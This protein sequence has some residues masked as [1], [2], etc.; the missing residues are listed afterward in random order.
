MPVPPEGP[1]MG[2]FVTSLQRRL[3]SEVPKLHLLL[4]GT[5]RPT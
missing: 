3:F 4:Y 1:G 2:N 5:I